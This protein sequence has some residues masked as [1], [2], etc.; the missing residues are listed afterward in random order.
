MEKSSSCTVSSRE[1]YQLPR[2]SAQV[3]LGHHL[4]PGF[5]ILPS[6]FQPPYEMTDSTHLW[7]REINRLNQGCTAR[8]RQ[9]SRVLGLRPQGSGASPGY[10]LGYQEVPL[11]T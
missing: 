4:A 9:D 3:C 8:K 2:L 6:P 7:L 11:F 5:P 1:E 10:D